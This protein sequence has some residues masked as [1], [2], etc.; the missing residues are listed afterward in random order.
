MLKVLWI[1][2]YPLKCVKSTNNGTEHPEHPVPWTLELMREI[3]NHVELTIASQTKNLK[4]IVKIKE[5]DVQFLFCPSPRL[6]YDLLS[7]YRI[8]IMRLSKMIRK[9]GKEF[10]VVHVHGTE[11]QYEEVARRLRLP[12]VISMQ[13]LMG[14]YQRFYPNKKSAVYASWLLSSIYEKIGVKRSSNF[15]CRTKFD[16]GFV[17][18]LNP[19]ARIFHNWEL[20]RKEF[21]SNLNSEDSKTLLFIGGS[22]NFK[23]FKEALT[24]LDILKKRGRDFKLGICGN[25]SEKE[26]E[27]AIELYNL[28]LTLDDFHLYGFQSAN[29]L[30]VLFQKSFCLLHPSYLDNSPNSVCEAQV[31]GFPVIA[32][33]V[34]GVGSLIRNNE[35]GILI[36]RY[37]SVGLADQVC[38]L[39]DD[40]ILYR[41]ISEQS[42]SVARQRHDRETIV[43]TTMEIYN[44]ISKKR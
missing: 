2:S 36:D 9:H 21:H 39:H 26:I 35:T 44:E 4:E 33:D 43:G 1:A 13:G 8:R 24:C 15:I 30:A 17:K 32:S 38:R 28:N 23:G 34:G 6:R 25:C 12:Y 31:A 3:T 27:R 10:D 37:D 22:N 29:Q 20:I 11:H 7:L 40:R 42:I 19:E 41:R 5:N 14:P 18:R 16:K